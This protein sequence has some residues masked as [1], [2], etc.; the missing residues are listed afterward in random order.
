MRPFRPGFRISRVDVVALILGVIGAV[1]A[2]RV[3]WWMGLVVGCAVGHFFLFCNVFR[4][5][6]PLELAWASVF[7]ATAG[8][9]IALGVPG[10]PIAIGATICTTLAVVGIQMRSPAYHGVAWQRI[11]PGL[12]QWWEARGGGPG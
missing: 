1:A 10:W 5:A 4:I 9:T 7:V 8:G 3:E 11:N 12:P 6:R 2:G